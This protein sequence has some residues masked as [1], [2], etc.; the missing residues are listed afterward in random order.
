MNPGVSY[1]SPVNH[2]NYVDTL[3]YLDILEIYDRFGIDRGPLIVWEQLCVE[4]H[5]LSQKYFARSGEEVPENLLR[6]IIGYRMAEASGISCQET[7]QALKIGCSDMGSQVYNCATTGDPSLAPRGLIV[8][9][10]TWYE[11]FG[12]GGPRVSVWDYIL[13]TERTSRQFRVNRAL[14][15]SHT[16]G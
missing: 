8:R 4:I 11:F 6:I 13:G 2:T 14:F 12:G 15:I 3:S 10:N 7:A 5:A 1:A 9:E 16:I